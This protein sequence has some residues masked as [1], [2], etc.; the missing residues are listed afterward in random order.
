M[1]LSS[2]C[3]RVVSVCVCVCLCVHECVCLSVVVGVFGGL[4]VWCVSDR[5]CV[6]LVVCVSSELERVCACGVGRREGGAAVVLREG[7]FFVSLNVFVCSVYFIA[8]VASLQ[9]LV[10]F[11]NCIEHVGCMFVHVYLCF[12]NFSCGHIFHSSCL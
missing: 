7:F 12:F 6:S 8:R 11:I 10:F 5:G 9:V 1:C 2:V 3:V 4:C